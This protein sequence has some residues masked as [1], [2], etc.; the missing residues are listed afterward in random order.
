MDTT[1]H[2]VSTPTLF[3]VLGALVL[4]LIAGVIVFV[5][6][7]NVVNEGNQKEATLTAV[8]TDGANYLSNCVVKTERTAG[9][10]KSQTVA[11]DKV[12]A[13]AVAGRYGTGNTMDKAKLFSAITEAYPD[14]SVEGLNKSFNNALEVI[15]GCQDDFARKQSVIID[16]VRLF[17]SWKTGN[18]T[19]RFFGGNNF[20]NE[21]L[22]VS[23]PG[24]NLTGAAALDKIRTPI[25]D[26]QTTATYQTGEQSLD[27][28]FAAK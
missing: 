10:L 24:I 3:I 20:P 23:L 16:N 2:K 17:D 28:P 13:D 5:V 14:S 22:R 19:V 7:Q 6:N 4:A 18:T 12:L 9:L 21:N 27:D 1:K 26:S 25:V 8:Y 11:V 15:T